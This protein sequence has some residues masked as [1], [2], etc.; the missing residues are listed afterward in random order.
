MKSILIAAFLLCPLLA[1][2][3]G[4][5]IQLTPQTDTANRQTTTAPGAK[6]PPGPPVFETFEAAPKLS[7]FPRIGDYRPEEDEGER[8]AYW[9]TYMQH[10]TKTSGVVTLP[11]PQAHAGRVFSL[12]SVAGLDS[13]GYFSSLAVEPNTRYRLSVAVHADL[14]AGATAGIGLLEF[15]EFLWVGE[16]YTQSLARKHQVGAQPGLTLTGLH[17][18]QQQAL[19]F[20]TGERTRMVHL[21]LYREGTPD[22]KPILF[23]DLRVEK[24]E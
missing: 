18:W 20:T 7:L 11:L 19:T 5:K 4:R 3:D 21:V 22:R 8:L 12:R 9:R 1:G 10:L 24:A 15:D 16:Q 6:T 17:D 14:P 2:C 13:L 23:D